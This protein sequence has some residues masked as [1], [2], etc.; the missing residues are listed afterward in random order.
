MSALTDT[1]ATPRKG[2]VA[3]AAVVAVVVAL[4]TVADANASPPGTFDRMFK[5]L[6]PFTAPTEQQIADLAQAMSDP[7]DTSTDSPGV[8]SGFTFFGQFVDHDLTLDT[9]PSPI[10]PV[11][12]RM[13]D[14]DRNGNF[15][16]D[17]VYGD[18]PSG[19][20][21]LYEPDGKHLRT[22]VS[23]GVP[24]VPRRSDGSA[25]LGDA[26]DDENLILVQL[27]AAFLRFH[28]R[29]VDG[30]RTFAEAQRLTRYHYQW[31]VL[32]DYLPRVL[33]A[34]T[35]ERF[36]GAKRALYKP[37]NKH[38]PVLPVEFAVAAF[39]FGHSQVRAGYRLNATTGGAIFAP[40]GF[41]LRGGRPLPSG[42]AIEWQHFFD[43]DGLPG[44]PDPSKLID[45]KISQ[46]L[47]ALPI[48]GVAA[49]GSNVLAFR[50]MVRGKF[51]GLPSGEDVARA[52]GAPVL[53]ASGAPGFEDGTPLWFYILRE[54]ELRENGER[55]GPVGARI[56]G[57]VLITNLRRDPDSYL[58]ASPAFK[59][60]VPHAGAFTMGDFLR[61]ARVA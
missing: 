20:P 5:D 18:G 28:N 13:L 43:I 15:D 52:I 7:G 51:Y 53:P 12:I 37:A 3:F 55:V 17:S 59:P 30:G 8:P 34:E 56:I 40:T 22:S 1:L 24:D 48:P 49:S 25:I 14:N 45:T 6:A 47:F 11:N 44:V 2:A 19:T 39:R 46:P 16:L 10:A 35:V 42:T 41:D 26:R 27:H 33:G 4:I 9:E 36:L 31:I 54:S 38:D 58:N 57:D 60:S 32:H 23:N 50:N 61:F 21:E 29:L